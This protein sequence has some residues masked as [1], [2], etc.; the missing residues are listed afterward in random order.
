MKNQELG[1]KGILEEKEQT[2]YEKILEIVKSITDLYGTEEI[3]ENALELEEE[4]YKSY[5][6]ECGKLID[7]IVELVKLQEKAFDFSSLSN[8]IQDEEFW[9]EI[10]EN[11]QRKTKYFMKVLPYRKQEK[12]RR[13]ELLEK[14]FDILYKQ[15]ENRQFL[16]ET[17]EEEALANALYE[18]FQESEY[19]IM[20]LYASKRRFKKFVSDNS[21]LEDEDLEY[22]WELYEQNFSAVQPVALSKRNAR[23][24]NMVNY[25]IR[26]V[27]ALE[28]LMFGADEEDSEERR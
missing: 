21:C 20:I 22:I 19:A 14:G 18:I 7:A 26:R 10:Q 27:D 2:A 5:Q 6:K 11:V 25:L 13:L 4:E 23:L 9:K 12:E 17:I 16:R 1:E 8:E 24:E 28:N 3:E 15:R